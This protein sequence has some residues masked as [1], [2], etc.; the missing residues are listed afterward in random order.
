[1]TLTGSD[2]DKVGR[3]C[4]ILPKVASEVPQSASKCL[5]VAQTASK[6]ASNRP[7]QACF[8]KTFKKGG[9]CA[10]SALQSRTFKKSALN[11]ENACE[12]IR[13][14]CICRPPRR[15]Q[16]E[17]LSRE[18]SGAAHKSCQRPYRR[19]HFTLK[20]AVLQAVTTEVVTE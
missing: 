3:I 14:V 20:G 17:C 5:K 4:Q 19:L 15:N 6:S 12:P 13:C 8:A 18:D 16:I 1:M 9:R 11:S 7:K 10:P 2:K